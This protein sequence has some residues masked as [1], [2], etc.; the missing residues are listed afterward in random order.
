[1]AGKAFFPAKAVRVIAWVLRPLFWAPVVIAV[2]VG[3][4]LADLWVFLTQPLISSLGTMLLHPQ[5]MLGAFALLACATLFHEFGHATAC[6]YGGGKPGV[7]GGGV[8]LMFPAF[9]TDVTDSYRLSRR[10][11]LRVDLGGVYFNA[12]WVVVAAV[13][14][15]FYPYPPTLVILAFSNLTIIQQL[16]PVVRFD[17][18]WVLSDLVGVPDL[19]A[20][21]GPAIKSMVHRRRPVD[22]TWKATLIV[23][24][25]VVIVVPLLLVSMALLM[26]RMPTFLEHSYQAFLADYHKAYTDVAHQ[27]WSAAVL[28]G[29]LMV[30]LALP[31]LGFTIMF[32]RT[33]KTMGTLVV[34]KMPKRYRP[35]H[36]MR[37][38]PSFEEDEP[39][40]MT[41]LRTPAHK[42]IRFERAY[43]PPRPLPRKRMPTEPGYWPGP[44]KYDWWEVP[45]EE[46]ALWFW[47]RERGLRPPGQRVYGPHEIIPDD[48]ADS[49]PEVGGPRQ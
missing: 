2:L 6:R 40:V 30:F 20:R 32:F 29:L 27:L 5:Y 24:S 16:I 33:G 3:L 22:L 34:A 4:V 15:R 21:I 8:Y 19:F 49:G 43:M 48:P 9:Y 25:W 28:T 44:K 42:P 11:R 7:I 23:T 37:E 46:E 31:A 1:M 26:V 12:V 13:M 39:Y 38:P 18:Y 41:L 17:G 45:P 14:Y 47:Y 35:V 10:A 36:M